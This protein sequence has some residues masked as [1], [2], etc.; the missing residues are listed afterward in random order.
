MKPIKFSL[1][2][3]L[4]VVGMTALAQTNS[5][6]TTTPLGSDVTVTAITDNILRVTNIPTGST[7]PES[8]TTVSGLKPQ[9]EVH[10]SEVGGGKMLST[11][12]GLRAMLHDQT[13]AVAIYGGNGRSVSD[14]GF[15]YL[16]KDGFFALSLT[17]S[18]N[19]SFY[20]A[21][22]RGHAINLTGDTLV[23]YN[24]ASYGYDKQDSRS[25]RLNITMPLVISSK[26]YALLFDDYAAAEL[27]LNNPL[28]YVTE[29]DDPIT[30]YYING[31]GSIESTV[32]ELSVLTGRQPIAPFWALGYITSRYGYRTQQ[33]AVNAVDSLKT[34]GYPLDGIVLDHFW[35]G[36][37]EDMGVL[38]WDTEA[39]PDPDKML[40]DFKDRDINTII[41]TEPFVLKNRKGKNNYEYLDEHRMMARDS[42][43][44]TGGVSIWVGDG[45]LIDVTNPETRQWYKNIYRKNTERGVTGWWGD[46]GEPE[47]HPDSLVHYNGKTARQYHNLYGNDW[48]SI[49]SELFEEDYPDTRLFSLMRSGTV[50]LQRYSI[51]PWSGDIARSWGGLQA[52]VPVMI[53][54]G[55]SGLGYMS[56]DV[57]GFATS[58]EVPINPELYIR[59]L[60]V[61]LFTP[62]LRT[63][64]TMYSEPYYY[65][66]NQDIILP[67]IKERYAWLPYNY[68]LAYE[69]A[70]E[71]LPLVRPLNF[72]D[73]QSATY[74]DIEDEY[75]WGRDILVAPVMNEGQT[76]RRV[77]FPTGTWLDLRNTR[78]IYNGGDTIQYAAPL[79]VIPLFV[80]AGSF[81]PRADYKMENTTDYR[82]DTY[83][84]DYY[85]ANGK[86]D[87]LIYEDN[88][89]SP[90][91]LSTGSYSLIH[92]NGDAGT[93]RTSIDISAELGSDS[94]QAANPTKTIILRIHNITTKPK[95][96]KVDGRKHSC[97]YNRETGV[98]TITLTWNTASPVSIV[99]TR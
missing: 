95:G 2:G 55:L 59:W 72:Y 16:S 40:S 27:I 67:L 21:G 32:R 52:Q 61:G 53:G 19:E 17:T 76:L 54:S 56:H 25:N 65:T 74:D 99:L 30:Y 77:V 62:T 93:N 42:A 96:L 50:G 14:R 45:G 79:S 88:M 4:S 70:S 35:F 81:I 8:R 34:A 41:I 24:K 63:H 20:G 89:K 10:T 3:V 33:Q 92:F 60:Q 48:A 1:F 58:P 46:L 13:G 84:V 51:F 6:S 23:M 12:T 85:P 5:I 90:D 73:T 29:S 94:F 38:D 37:G 39:F 82:T 75:L 49:V 80:R 26:G 44:N 78:K 83:T 43:G 71:G 31:T 98:V 47:M 87:G 36:E 69:N 22:E 97:T 57:G 64:S 66:E 68:T 9:G 28:E 86:S 18:G 91:V 11:A 15:R 7:V